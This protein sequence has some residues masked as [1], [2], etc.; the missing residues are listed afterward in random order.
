GTGQSV[1]AVV[2]G[3]VSAVF[4][5]YP[6]LAGF[7]KEGKVKLIAVNSEKRSSLAPDIATIAETSIPG[8]DFA[9][10]IGFTGPAGIAPAIAHKIAADVAV[11]ARLVL[12]HDRLAPLLAELLADH[13]RDGVGK[14]AR[15]VRYDDR[16]GMRRIGGR[17]RERGTRACGEDGDD[18]DRETRIHRVSYARL[19]AAL[20]SSFSRTMPLREAMRSA[21]IATAISGGVREPIVSPTG[22]RSRAICEGRRSK[23]ASRLRRSALVRAE[24]TA[25]T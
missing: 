9:P 22:P 1:P 25:P 21:R 8:F 14:P 10:K 16:D 5:A 13:A 7:A 12:D 17:L 4:S 11:S 18:A 20:R 15:R 19:S 2:S 6:S 3:Q 23:S 24:P